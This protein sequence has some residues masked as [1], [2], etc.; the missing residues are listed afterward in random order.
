[1]RYG[2][3][4]GHWWNRREVSQGEKREL[5]ERRRNVVEEKES[6]GGEREGGEKE[7]YLKRVRRRRDPGEEKYIDA[8][9]KRDVE[10]LE[11][12]DGGGHEGSEEN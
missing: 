9:M 8:E 12:E 7:I 1:M 10:G 11:K 6:R 3:K 2:Q 5:G 4:N